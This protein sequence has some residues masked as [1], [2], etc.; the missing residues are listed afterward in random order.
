M[1]FSFADAKEATGSADQSAEMTFESR[2]ILN[3][4]LHHPEDQRAIDLQ[5]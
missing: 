5:T 1:A 3:S 4:G 2:E